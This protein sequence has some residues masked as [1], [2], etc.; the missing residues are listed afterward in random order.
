MC[1]SLMRR[2]Y[3]PD[4]Q[5]PLGRRHATHREQAGRA[6]WRSATCTI[7][8]VACPGLSLE[9]DLFLVGDG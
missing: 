8:F 5:K 9:G 1:R 6:G 7:T 4:G 3:L 2:H